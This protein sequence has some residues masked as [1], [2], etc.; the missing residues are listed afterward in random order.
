MKPFVFYGWRAM[1]RSGD[2]V[3]HTRGTFRM[4]HQRVERT[5]LRPSR[6]A[7]CVLAFH[8]VERLVRG[9]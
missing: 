8:L 6:H 1:I 9:Q 4:A 7:T 3:S 2:G 5:R